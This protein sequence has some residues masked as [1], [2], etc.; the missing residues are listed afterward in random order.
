MSAFLY[1][2]ITLFSV[3]IYFLH[4]KF[5]HWQRK[6][7]P[8]LQA[9]PLMGNWRQLEDM[10]FTDLMDKLYQRFKSSECVAGF[11]IYTQPVALLLDLDL[12]KTAL[13]KDFN[14]FSNRFAYQNSKDLTADN[15]F[16]WDSHKWR[17]MR[18]KFST[19]FTPSK[20][21]YMFN[22]MNA[23]AMQLTESFSKSLKTSDILN[24]TD[25]S[26]RFTTDV[27]A[28]C[29]MG[30][31]SRSLNFEPSDFY[32]IAPVTTGATDFSIRWKLFV[33]TYVRLVESIGI[34][35]TMFPQKLEHFYM[36]LLKNNFIE[37]ERLNIRRQDLLDLLIDL[38]KIKDENGNSILSH[39]EIASNLFL[40]FAAGY[41]SSANTISYSL[42]EL[43]RHPEL[44][45]K[46]R[47]EIQSVLEE[48][49]NELSYEACMKMTY[50]DQIISETNR[51]YPI[52]S[53]LERVTTVDY[54]IP[55][56]KYVLDKGTRV[57]VPVRS[58]H[59]DPEIYDNPEEFCP[60]R[61]DPAEVKRRHPQAYLAFGDGPRNCI[62]VRLGRLQV[63]TAMVA[64]LSNF[65][66][67]LC[68]KTMEQPEYSKHTFVLKNINDI[69]LKVEK[70][71]Q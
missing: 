18:S 48:Y 40:F 66:F 19:I 21:K 5:Q 33:E 56:T 70:L 49:N 31:E 20:I 28:N 1:V 25:L 54:H 27:I 14:D 32:D 71:E 61:F 29:I 22:T 9:H 4:R 35:V 6:G 53:Y 23:A 8:T 60:E 13:V 37:R 11:Y 12:V 65:K 2:V 17:P 69:W 62:G 52:F 7:I 57:F 39:G 10:H 64:M 55:N 51:L 41:E 63:T 36:D 44:Q 42:W 46:V 38:R 3:F 26:G 30:C 43:A 34:H 47:H 59:Y 45:D 16:F 50:L 68:D 15:L 58:I 24:I 67:S